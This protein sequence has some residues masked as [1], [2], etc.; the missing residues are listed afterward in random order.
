MI[1]RTWSGMDQQTVIHGRFVVSDVP[2]TGVPSWVTQFKK[3]GCDYMYGIY[4][5]HTLG[6][7]DRS[8][9]VV[10]HIEEL[11]T[12]DWSTFEETKMNAYLAPFDLFGRVFPSRDWLSIMCSML[13]NYPDG[14][15]LTV[16]MSDT[17]NFAISELA[18][19]PITTEL[20]DAYLQLI[21]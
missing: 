18:D 14:N 20:G 13:P 5:L 12:W 1:T 11:L 15:K 6:C 7:A 8:D 3:T 9:R 10:P 4:R 19:Q 2:L 17:H 16:Y 21:K